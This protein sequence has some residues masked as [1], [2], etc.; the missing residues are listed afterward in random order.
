MSS[1]TR[2]LFGSTPW[3]LERLLIGAFAIVLDVGAVVSWVVAG[4]GLVQLLR[5]KE[6]PAA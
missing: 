4:A 6:L 5:G 1:S 2:T 3:W